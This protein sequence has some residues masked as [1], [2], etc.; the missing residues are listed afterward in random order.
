MIAD[1]IPDAEARRAFLAC[2][3]HEDHVAVELRAGTLKQDGGHHG[4]EQ[5]ALVVDDAAAV[6]IT[7]D[8]RAAKRRNGP[9]GS[10]PTLTVSL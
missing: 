1:Q 2:L 4:G 3:G 7:A 5:I 9:L 10:G 8:A 6:Y